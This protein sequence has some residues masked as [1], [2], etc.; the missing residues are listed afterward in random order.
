MKKLPNKF[1]Q[2]IPW[3]HI[4]QNWLHSGKTNDKRVTAMY[5]FEPAT[6]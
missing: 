1:C 2:G 3:L 6:L 5:K 4:K